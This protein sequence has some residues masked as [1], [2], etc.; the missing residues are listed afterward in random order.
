MAKTPSEFG[1]ISKIFGK[2]KLFTI[3]TQFQAKVIPPIVEDIKTLEIW[4]SGNK[5]ALLQKVQLTKKDLPYKPKVTS[6]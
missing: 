4:G 5:Q 3:S 1:Q 6:K 2:L